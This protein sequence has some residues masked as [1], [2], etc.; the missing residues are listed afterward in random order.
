MT[1]EQMRRRQLLGEWAGRW[2][3]LGALGLSRVKAAMEEMERYPTRE[4]ESGDLFQ[5]GPPGGQALTTEGGVPYGAGATATTAFD[6]MNP[7]TWTWKHYL[8]LGGVVA[9]AMWLDRHY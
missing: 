9:S 3:G 7:L 5:Q 1:P 6:L 4:S 8:V 2:N